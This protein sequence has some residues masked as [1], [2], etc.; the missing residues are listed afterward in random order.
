MTIFNRRNAL[1]GFITVKALERRLKRRRR[2]TRRIATFVA[3]GL[4]SGGVLAALA[5]FAVR[6]QRDTQEGSA[7]GQHLEGYAVAEEE[8]GT[9]EDFSPPEPAPA[10]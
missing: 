5:L 8:A 4:V 1:V 3:L 10:A 6:R 7:Q 9:G 2:N